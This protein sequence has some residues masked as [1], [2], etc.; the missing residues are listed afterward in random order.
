MLVYI[1]VFMLGYVI[2][3]IIKLHEK[4]SILKYKYVKIERS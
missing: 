4:K 1:A 2:G 3:S